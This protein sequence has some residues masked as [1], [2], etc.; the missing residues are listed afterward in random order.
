MRF[1]KG[2]FGAVDRAAKWLVKCHSKFWAKFLV[3][4]VLIAIPPA[5][6]MA[7][8]SNQAVKAFVTETT[9]TFAAPLQN[10]PMIFVGLAAIYPSVLIAIGKAISRRA[11]TCGVHID[12][13]LALVGA[14]DSV[15][16]LKLQRFQKFC[17]Q[18]NLTA[19]DAFCAITMPTLQIQEIT[20]AICEFFNAI[21]RSDGRSSLIR[22]VLARMRN[23]KIVELPVYF[24]ND[25]P[26]T[27]SIGRLNQ[28][29]AIICAARD[30]RIV[31][32]ES[33]ATEL[34]KSER[35]RR[36]VE[37]ESDSDNRGSIIC[38]PIKGP[39]QGIPYVVSIHCEDDGYFKSSQADMYASIL[40]RFALR[41]NLEYSL[42]CLKEKLCEPTES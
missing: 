29:S 8:Y 28:K 20:R 10:L 35:R 30:K 34:K 25:E 15:V 38:F 16:G 31:V 14:L 24:P 39:S 27:V 26:P 32:I 22:V 1:S 17:Q 18:G 6:V 4:P 41:L 13:I 5:F 21:R 36:F 9:P 33:I 3:V 2:A 12:T 37:V 19:Q 42:L 11:E 40:E 7:F 23:G